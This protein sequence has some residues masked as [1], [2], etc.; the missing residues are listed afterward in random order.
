LSTCLASWSALKAGYDA[1]GLNHIG[2]VLTD[3]L[4]VFGPRDLTVTVGAFASWGHKPSTLSAEVLARAVSSKLPSFTPADLAG[5]IRPLHSIHVPLQLVNEQR[6]GRA[7]C[8]HLATFTARQL[9]HVLLGFAV[10]GCLPRMLRAQSHDLGYAVMCMLR[11]LDVFQVE[12]LLYTFA[13]LNLLPRS[14][15][16]P[17]FAIELRRKAIPPA[18]LAAAMHMHWQDLAQDFGGREGFTA[19]SRVLDWWNLVSDG[20][21]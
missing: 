15:D 6:L 1:L 10:H 7:V 19:V 8:Q 5:I 4:R 14:V 3:K 2:G 9:V 20:E 21:L 16:L 11:Q 13:K 17:V 12:C 18:T